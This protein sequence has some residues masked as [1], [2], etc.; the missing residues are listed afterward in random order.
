MATRWGGLLVFLAAASL[1]QAKEPELTVLAMGDSTTAGAP[2]F[3]SPVEAPPNGKGNPQS[4][5][6]YWA[7]QSLPHLRFLNR[8][9]SGERTDQIFKRFKGDLKTLRPNVVILLAGVNDLF[10]DYPS[11]Q[12]EEKLDKM[13]RFVQEQKISLIACS[14]I[15]YNGMSSYDYQR[16]REVNEWIEK[17]SRKLGIGFCDLFSAM[18]DPAHPSHLISTS[19]DL[20]PD[21]DGYRRMGETVAECLKMTVIFS[22]EAPDPQES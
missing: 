15:P 17:R 4:Q 1:A 11:E 5:Y 10:Q 7:A 12:I 20:H 22:L 8:G 21:V 2:G 14:I 18:E 19:D 6:T 3:R 13:Y 16:M 9:V